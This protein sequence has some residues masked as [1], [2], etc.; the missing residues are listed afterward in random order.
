MIAFKSMTIQIKDKSKHWLMKHI[1]PNFCSTLWN[2]FKNSSTVWVPSLPWIK[3]R[4]EVLYHELLHTQQQNVWWYM[5]YIFSP[6]SRGKW[7]SYGYLAAL[8]YLKR[9]FPNINI[10]D[11]AAVY[12]QK[13]FGWGPYLWM[14]LPKDLWQT[15]LTNIMTGQ[16]PFA[17]NW[18]EL[19][20]LQHEV[21]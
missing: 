15:G 8:Y 9:F 2:P 1:A 18:N 10:A 17:A 6:W 21:S 20:I 19:D 4:P 13:Y 14:P 11:T 5:S 7:E 3:I 12:V 16:P